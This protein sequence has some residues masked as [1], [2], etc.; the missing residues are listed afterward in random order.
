[1][2]GVLC[3]RCVEALHARVV[4]HVI[5]AERI[6]ANDTPLPVLEPGRGRTK[7]GRLWADTHDDRPAGGMAPPAVAFISA[8]DRRG[9]RPAKHLGSFRGILQVDGH[10][11]FEP[12]AGDGTIARA[13]CGSP[14]SIGT[15]A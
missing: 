5:A 9:A 11:G 7:T 13:A 12:L 4:V 15:A 1:M 3:R 2:S 10:A 6:V 14:P 8:A